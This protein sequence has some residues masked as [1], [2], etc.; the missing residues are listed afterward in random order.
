[1]KAVSALVTSSLISRQTNFSEVLRIS[2]PGSSPASIRIW[3][4]LQ[5][6]STLTPLAARS[7]TVSMIGERAAIAPQRK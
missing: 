5:T 3:K 4:P 6:P 1:V 2:A 7:R